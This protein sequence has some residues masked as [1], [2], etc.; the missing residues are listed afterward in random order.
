VSPGSLCASGDG[1]NA[2]S[3]GKVVKVGFS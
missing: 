2:T 1:V 3:M